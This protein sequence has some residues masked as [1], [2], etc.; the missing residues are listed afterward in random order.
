ML[1]KSPELI[2]LHQLRR[3][4]SLK[5]TAKRSLGPK[6]AVELTVPMLQLIMVKVIVL[7]QHRNAVNYVG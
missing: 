1:V 3:E 7:F 4:P 2:V 5:I 6:A